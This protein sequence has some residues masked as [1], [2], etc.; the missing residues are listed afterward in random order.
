MFK[1]KVKISDFIQSRNMFQDELKTIMS[2]EKFKEI[3]PAIEEYYKNHDERYSHILKST[4]NRPERL[5]G[6]NV[7]YLIHNY[8][9]RSKVLTE[10][11]ISSVNQQNV[12]CSSILLRS[13]MEVTGAIGFLLK[14]LRSFYKETITLEK[15]DED[16]KRLSLGDRY[17]KDWEK[18]V[19]PHTVMCLIDAVDDL[20][21]QD[22][23]NKGKKFR[24]TYELL[25]EFS[26]P[27][28][29]GIVVGA[30]I[31]KNY[32]VRFD[33]ESKFSEEH[34]E[35]LYHMQISLGLFMYFFDE[36]KRLL[37]E[38]EEIPILKN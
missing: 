33:R 21:K 30:K 15:L 24:D 17:R 29:L 37:N 20:Y 19:K 7:T 10:G 4:P 1:K 5:I 34:L 9:Y 14:R 18:V 32:I 26:H 3:L 25:C 8:L 35:I 16:I 23:G 31:N 12:I 22:T 6:H 11:W 2:G 28:Y 27:N 36:V 38:H 13:H